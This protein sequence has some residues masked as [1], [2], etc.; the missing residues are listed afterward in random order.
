MQPHIHLDETICT[1]YAIL[2]GDPA[3][4]DRLIPFLDNYEEI[5]FN[6]EYRSI[7]GYY[8]GIKILGMSTGMGGVSAA[9][10]IEELHNIGVTTLIRIGS[11]G[12]LV[13]GIE[14]G[15]LV[16]SSGCVRDDGTSHAYIRATYPAVPD[17][18][19][20][21]AVIEAAREGGYPHHIG[22][23]RSHETFY[24]QQE[25]D[26]EEYWMKQ[27]VLCDDMETAPLFVVGRLRGMKCASILNNVVAF[28]GDKEEGVGSYSTSVRSAAMTGERNEILTALEA[29][30]KMEGK[31]L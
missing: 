9:I 30:A 29:I 17:T 27:N 11:C 25:I 3:R 7:T 22:V 26:Q 12:T 15:D 24:S 19:L 28:A 1:K 23:T 10:G 14:V 5:T 4:L 31:Q 6:R 20:L 13:P 16:I 8:K 18:E 2:P 21:F